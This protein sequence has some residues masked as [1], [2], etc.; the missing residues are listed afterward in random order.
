MII[1]TNGRRFFVL[2]PC[3]GTAQAFVDKYHVAAC[4]INMPTFYSTTLAFTIL[5]RISSHRAALLRSSNHYLDSRNAGVESQVGP[6]GE[7]PN[8]TPW[9]KSL[10][11]MASLGPQVATT[12]ET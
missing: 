8:L 9:L 4:G 3:Q 10:L 1:S 5:R 7:R 2:A 11:I 6:R 12:R